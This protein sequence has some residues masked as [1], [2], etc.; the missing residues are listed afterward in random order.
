MQRIAFGIVAFL[1][2]AAGAQ[3]PERPTVDLDGTVRGSAA[4][5]LSKFLSPQAQA[6]F[7]AMITRPPAAGRGRRGSA[8]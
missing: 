6:Q 4:V 7:K 1:A 2:T 5:P 3:A 8:T